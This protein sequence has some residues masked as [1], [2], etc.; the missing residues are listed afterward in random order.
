MK[1]SLRLTI[2]D[3]RF[4]SKPH[5][6]LDVW[7][8]SIR[9]VEESYRLVRNFPKYEE[10][11]ITSQIRRSAV[12]IPA[13]IAEGAA[14]QTKKEFIQ[15]LHTAQGSLSE[16]DTHLEISKNLNYI[17]EASISDISMIMGDIDRMLTGLIKSVKRESYGNT[18]NRKS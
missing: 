3:S 5:K 4:L 6:N 10:Y 16:L 13:N 15:F 7:Q 18:V 17:N 9:L 1:S 12:S 8:R 14:R 2:Y 11:G